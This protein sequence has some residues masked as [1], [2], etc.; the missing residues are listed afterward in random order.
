[1]K[2][3]YDKVD[4]YKEKIREMKDNIN[5]ENKIDYNDE[6]KKIFI[7]YL[8]KRGMEK[9]SIIQG[10]IVED[11]KY[12][13]DNK[14]KIDYLYYIVNQMMKPSIQFLELLMDNPHKIFDKY[15]NEETNRRKGKLDVGSYLDDNNNKSVDIEEIGINFNNKLKSV[16]KKI[17]KRKKK[18]ISVD[19]KYKTNLKTNNKGKI[20]LDM[21]F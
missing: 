21:I 10:D 17:N 12:I 6:L 1:M 2:E 20:M 9:A 18:N 7:F 13:V 19:E 16:D 5:E 4:Y 3:N 11:P 15:I 8:N 14:L